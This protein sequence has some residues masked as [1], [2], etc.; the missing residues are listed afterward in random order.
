MNLQDIIISKEDLTK[1]YE[2]ID[3]GSEGEIYKYDENHA[4]KVYPGLIS[5]KIRR[6]KFNKIELLTK[7]NDDS[8]TFPLGLIYNE[9]GGKEG[10]LMKYINTPYKQKNF[11]DLRF[12]YQY[13]KLLDYIIKASDALERVHQYGITIGDLRGENIL[14]DE[15]NN[16]VFIDTDNY[17]YQNYYYNLICYNSYYLRRA[18]RKS[19]SQVENDKYLF[20]M[21]CMQLFTPGIVIENNQTDRFFEEMIKLLD[22]PI[23]YKEELRQIFSDASNK[24]YIGPVLKRINPKT[25]LLSSQSVTKLNCL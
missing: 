3:W 15:N 9:N 18:F 17:A 20:A 13:D 12:Y 22:I 4:F 10:Y 24:P 14:I 6:N 11:D 25:K 21:L 7:L 19:Y 23:E 8:F 5:K 16:P 1:K 2:L